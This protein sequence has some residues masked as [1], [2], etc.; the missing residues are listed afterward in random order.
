MLAAGGLVLSGCGDAISSEAL[1]EEFAKTCATEFT[2]QGGPESMAEPF[3]DCSV[4]QIKEQ[5]LGPL[6]LVNQETMT[7]IGEDCMLSVMEGEGLMGG[8]DAAAAVEEAPAE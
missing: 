1:A 2:G 3:C 7:K 6:D 4:E 8:D 5:E